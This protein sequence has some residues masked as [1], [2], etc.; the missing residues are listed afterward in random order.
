M[1][2]KIKIKMNMGDIK[3]IDTSFQLM[4]KKEQ[5][6]NSLKEKLIQTFF[7]TRDFQLL[8]EVVDYLGPDIFFKYIHFIKDD[9][10]LGWIEKRG[11]FELDLHFFVEKSYYHILD[12]YKMKNV[13]LKNQ[14]IVTQ[15]ILQKLVTD[16]RI[17]EIEYFY[18]NPNVT[19]FEYRHKGIQQLNP[20]FLNEKKNDLHRLLL[21]LSLKESQF[22]IFEFLKEYGDLELYQYIQQIQLKIKLQDIQSFDIMIRMLIMKIY[23]PHYLKINNKE[24]SKKYLVDLMKDILLVGVEHKNIMMIDYLFE[25]NYQLE[26]N[27]FI[28][29]KGLFMDLDF[30]TRVFTKIFESHSIQIF[31]HV[32]D[33]LKLE[34][35]K[36]DVDFMIDLTIH[37]IKPIFFHQIY[38]HFAI[39]SYF[40]K[41]VREKILFYDNIYLYEELK[42]YPFM[43]KSYT[44]EE[45]CKFHS[46]ELLKHL[47]QK[48]EITWNKDDVIYC[49]NDI[50]KH[51][52]LRHLHDTTLYTLSKN[53]IQDT[54][55]IW[56]KLYKKKI[57]ILT[58]IHENISKESPEISIYPNIKYIFELNQF[59]KYDI[60]QIICNYYMKNIN[61]YQSVYKL[62]FKNL[63]IQ[64]DIK[65]IDIF[66]N[67]GF[68]FETYHLDLFIE[69]NYDGVM[70]FDI[71]K[72]LR[73]NM[74]INEKKNLLYTI[75]KY[76]RMNL[77]K[78]LILYLDYPYYEDS[79][80]VEI[81]I[82][83][84]NI[85]CFSYLH[86]D[87]K[88]PL[89]EDCWN[90][91][92]NNMKGQT[93]D[94]L[95]TNN[96]NII[97]KR[98][99]EILQLIKNS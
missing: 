75:I 50:E 71:V 12:Y 27:D 13:Y 98:T 35:Y 58:Y 86:K 32:I 30:M 18:K 69:Y 62:V 7:E 81:S 46:E 28:E 92:H 26:K 1:K 49:M 95:Y 68:Q 5:K 33:K 8:K 44:N 66:Y 34:K 60:L 64:Q 10:W 14:D 88:I 59:F 29:K 54:E 19:T 89:D 79:K 56:F 40:L 55:K 2:I 21:T 61:Q 83:N 43:S 9:K 97:K 63:F 39:D 87:L 24:P 84:L 96:P 25:L 90:I 52:F 31:L 20:Y 38:N 16:G 3:D 17:E 47:H 99:I 42:G 94:V 85:E 73:E 37:Y 36:F 15:V 6:K 65:S 78:N 91:I 80:L 76:G 82:Q 57:R 48:G 93:K 51:T 22:E 77:L 53:I 67:W 11:L 72:K 45:L 41:H 4:D 74:S 23:H 70:I